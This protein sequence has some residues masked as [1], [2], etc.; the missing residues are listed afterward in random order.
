MYFF[1][2]DALDFPSFDLIIRLGL[3]L[4]VTYF[5]SSLGDRMIFSLFAEFPQVFFCWGT[6]CPSSGFGFG[7]QMAHTVVHLQTWTLFGGLA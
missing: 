1:P 3:G 4:S 5:F 7:G 6:V 2:S